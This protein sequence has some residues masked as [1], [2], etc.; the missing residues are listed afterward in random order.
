MKAAIIVN[1]ASGKGKALGLLPKVVKWCQGQGIEFRLYPTTEPGDGTHQA[2]LAIQAEFERIVVLGGDG[3]INEV[4]QALIGTEKVMGVLPGGSGNDFFK[5]L[6]KDTNLEQSMKI[7]FL[8]LPHEVDAGLA[9]GRPFFNVLGIGFDARVAAEAVKSRIPGFAGYL[10]AVFKV[11]RSYGPLRLEIELDQLKLTHNV[12]LVSIGNGRTSG[13][14]FYLTPQAKF[15][16]GL[17][18]ICIMDYFP[19]SK[20]FSVLPR[21]LKGTHVR[22]DGVRVYRSRRILIRSSEKFPVHIDGEPLPEP[23][24]KLELMMD[25]RKLK[26]SVA[27][28]S[29]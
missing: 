15:D 3:T 29:L 24:E 16:D 23:L 11:W 4:G 6:S 13:G 27:E 20:I 21:A 2:R 22:L 14:G 1:P 19:K 17:F 10:W 18:D 26:I 12:T 5:M 8:G 7:A 9:N 28:E 25:N